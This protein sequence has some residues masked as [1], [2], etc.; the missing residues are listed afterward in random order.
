MDYYHSASLQAGLPAAGYIDLDT[1]DLGAGFWRHHVAPSKP[2]PMK[3]SELD[4]YSR[5][6]SHQQRRRR[7][8]AEGVIEDWVEELDNA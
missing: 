3:T 4:L 6:K 7:L 2:V 1:I 8:R 5:I